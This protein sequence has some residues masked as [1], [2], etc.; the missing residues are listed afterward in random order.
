MAMRRLIPRSS[1]VSGLATAIRGGH[2]HTIVPPLPP[3][4]RQPPHEKEVS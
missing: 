4:G 2:G 1:R 3:L